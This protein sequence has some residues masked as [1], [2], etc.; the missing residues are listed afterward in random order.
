MTLHSA[1]VNI[2]S[3]PLYHEVSFCVYYKQDVSLSF[4]F[5]SLFCSLLASS[6][7][8]LV[9]AWHFQHDITFTYCVLCHFPFVLWSLLLCSEGCVLFL[10]LQRLFRSFSA[11]SGTSLVN[12]WHFKHD[13]TFTCCEL[14]CFPF[15]LWSLLFV[16]RRMCPFPFPPKV[17]SF[18]LSQ[19]WH[20]PRTA[21]LDTSNVTLHSPTVKFVTFSLYCEVTYCV[22]KDV[23]FS[24]F[25]S[26]CSLFR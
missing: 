23:S 8:S 9:S 2:I 17:V 19:Q 20:K 10:S 16:F 21:V 24:F 7:R 26:L 11:S 6:G 14:C 1:T 5:Q 12:A 18:I 3:F 22:Q 4:S 13:I 15:V 25:F